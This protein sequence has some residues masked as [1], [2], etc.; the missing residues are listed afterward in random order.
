M[1]KQYIRFVQ[2]KCKNNCNQVG[3]VLY[4]ESFIL[5]SE[6]V[7]NFMYV[8]LNIQVLLKNSYKIHQPVI[9]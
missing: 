7:V 5:N 6:S 9:P 8:S 1:L 3:T 4:Q 2:Y